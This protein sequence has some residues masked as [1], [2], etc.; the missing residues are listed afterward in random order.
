MAN[1]QN[2]QR[3]TPPPPTIN[4][5]PGGGRPGPRLTEKPKNTKKT[6][7]RLFSYIGKSRR[8]LGLLLLVMVVS[9]LFTLVAPLLQGS[10]IDAIEPV[11]VADMG[12][13]EVFVT[14]RGGVDLVLSADGRELGRLDSGAFD[15]LDFSIRFTVHWGR[16]RYVSREG[17]TLGLSFFL[18]AMG[19][20][21]LVGALFN[22]WMQRLAA[23]LSQ[24]TVYTMRRE[25][26]DRIAVLPIRYTD[27]HRHGDLMSRMTGDVENVSTAVSQSVASLFSAVLTIVGA[28]VFMLLLSPI[29]TLVALFTIPLSIFVTTFLSKFMRKYFVRQQKLLGSLNGQVEEMV[30]SYK[31]VVAYGKEADALRTF[32]SI[33]GELR[34]C[35]VK[36]KVWGSIMGPVMNF[37]GNLQ[38]VLIAATGGALYLFFGIGTI[39][40]IQS[41]LQYSKN[42]TRPINEVASQFSS[43][44][45]ALAA[46]ERIFDVLDSEPE[47]DEGKREPEIVGNL[48]FRNVR[49]GY[50]KDEPVLRGFDLEVKAGEKIAIVGA[51]GSGKTTVIN[52]LTRF[53]EPDGGE[54]LVDGV[55]IH[56]IPKAY[57]RRHIGIVLQ[58]TVLFCDTVEKNILYGNSEADGEDVKKAASMAKADVF[59]ER[60]PEGYKTELAEGG[61]N[62]SAG[63]RQLLAITRA[64]IADPK[65]LILDEAT[66]NVDTRTEMDIQTALIRLMK[67]RT[68]LIIAHR[69]S[70]I[71]DA[72]KIVVIRGGCVAEI[73]NHD[74]L[75]SLG[76]EYA[77]LYQ[78]QFAGIVI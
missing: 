71:R 55:P 33:S 53:Y 56:E 38:Y 50:E 52:L 30:T 10:A 75:F 64:I 63:Q 8:T 17:E 66:S 7:G 62:L 32:A 16:E 69:L 74:E 4:M 57:L 15:D 28:L 27:T 1:N 18:I 22:F 54:I 31:T 47:V 9:T 19:T 36:A 65:I 60:L 48:S 45:T 26:F 59:V 49:F 70:T 76:G 21:A 78:S 68:S 40:T 34:V 67:N 37:I 39:G 13:E 61:S 43:I 73:G 51:T 23:K 14:R 11:K 2:T 3:E 20:A 5:R 58:D 25:L 41:M 24:Y 72:D 44:L 42:F 29:L 77:K 35:A 46:A 6:L 12:G